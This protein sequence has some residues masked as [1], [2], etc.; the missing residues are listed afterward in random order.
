MNPQLLITVRNIKVSSLWYQ[1]VLGCQSGH[2]G[3]E[4]ERLVLN[5][6]DDHVAPPLGYA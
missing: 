5:G 1:A 2:G 4:Y 3:S 6:S